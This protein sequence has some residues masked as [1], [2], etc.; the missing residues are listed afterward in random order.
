M[1]FNFNSIEYRLSTTFTLFFEPKRSQK[2]L[3]LV[4]SLSRLLAVK[5]FYFRSK[6]KIGK[7]KAKRISLKLVIEQDPFFKNHPES[8]YL[9]STL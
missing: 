3:H 6:I 4:K 9:K 7:L 1:I 5:E 2:K 8:K